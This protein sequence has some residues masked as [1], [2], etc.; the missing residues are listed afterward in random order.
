[1]GVSARSPS[2]VAAASSASL[3]APLPA[4]PAAGSPLRLALVSNGKPNAAELLD[5]VAGELS[6]RWPG[7][8]VRR[9][10]KHSV[11]VPPDA[12]Q[13]AEIAEWAHATLNAVGD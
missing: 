12:E 5:A 7:L 9:W 8:E 11:S 13:V 1:M 4:P 10:R 2:G 6:K 3:A